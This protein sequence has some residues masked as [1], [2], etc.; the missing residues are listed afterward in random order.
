MMNPYEIVRTFEA[1]MADYAGSRYAVAV[2]S[3]T[4]ALFLCCRY[5]NVEKVEIP[6]RTYCSVPCSIIHAGGQ[7][8]FKDY[9]WKG[10][11]ELKPYRIID[12]SLQVRRGMYENGTYRC[13]SFHSKKH[14]PIGRG[15]MILCDNLKAVEWFKLARYHGRHEV[16][17]S[18]DTPTMIGWHFSMEPE[19][20]AR[21]LL[22]LS[23]LP[24]N[25][26]DIECTDPDL[27]QNPIYQ[28]QKSVTR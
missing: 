25:N 19:R 17:L 21:G 20:A 3:C 16:P 8:E 22:L 28:S 13:L 4:A 18:E 23:T 9:S 27:S 7:V 2:D 10:A 24:D 14:I 11:Y 5:L 1:E 12:S 6:S 15:G 26:P